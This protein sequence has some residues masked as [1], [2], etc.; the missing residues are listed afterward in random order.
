M[1]KGKVREEKAM[2]IKKDKQRKMKKYVIP[3]M[4]TLILTVALLSACGTTATDTGSAGGTDTDS[5]PIYSTEDAAAGTTGTAAEMDSESPADASALKPLLEA[6]GFVVQKGSYY[7]LDTI[8]EAS[9]GRLMSCFGNNAGSAYAVFS[10]PD[11]PGQTVPNP[12]FLPIGW[13]YKL[14]QDEAI[15]LITSLPPECKYYSFANY[16]MFTQQ[17]EGKDYTNEKGFFSVG[18]E[19]TGLYHP[20]FGSIGDPVNMMNIRHDGDI[21]FDTTAVIVI[22]SNQ[23]VTDRV[24]AQ[25]YAAGY[26]DSMINIMPIPANTYK[27]GL[28]KGADTFLFLGRISQPTDREA[29]EQYL[30][31]LSENSIVYRLTP[32][33]ELEANPYE[34]QAVIPRGTGKHEAAQVDSVEEHLD[35]I[36]KA[37]IDQYKDEYDYQE[38]VTDIAV[39]E[40]LTAYFKDANAQGDNRDAAYLM[41]ENFTLDS[42]EDFIVVY[43]VN[44]TATGKAQYSNAVLYSRPMLNGICS[45]YDSLFQGSAAEYLEEECENPDQYYVYKLARTKT[46]DYTAVIEY[47]TDNE[48]GKYYGADNGSTLLMAFRAYLDETGTGASYYELIYDR[49]IVFHKK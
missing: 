28:D 21:K 12:E 37:I 39:P 22:S 34:N 26:D 18:D 6:S 14:C 44:H 33:S 36:R 29:Y 16:I 1:G 24:T 27:M 40:G 4:M 38:L 32:E 25:L 47:S 41:T 5:V 17:K 31:S 35:T 3:L 2:R 10:L 7:E 8:E 30:S 23:T 45:I 19:I 13:Q 20:I 46:D 43:G 49:A 48:K 15:V 11:A 42:D 9:A